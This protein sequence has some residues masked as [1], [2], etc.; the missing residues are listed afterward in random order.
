MTFIN[1]FTLP[2]D[3]E[4][5]GHKQIDKKYEGIRVHVDTRCPVLPETNTSNGSN[6]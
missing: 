5:Y 4:K 3:V 1:E 6:E 2:E